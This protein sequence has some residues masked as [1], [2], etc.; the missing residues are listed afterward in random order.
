MAVIGCC[1]PIRDGYET[2]LRDMLQYGQARGAGRG[3]NAGS[4]WCSTIMHN[5][6]LLDEKSINFF[7][8]ILKFLQ[9]MTIALALAGCESF[10]CEELLDRPE[11]TPIKS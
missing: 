4:G 5:G 1:V 11:Q 3:V 7:K 10:A 8:C 6:M 2:R 9:A